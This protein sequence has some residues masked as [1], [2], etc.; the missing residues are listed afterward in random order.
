M[1]SHEKKIE[2]MQRRAAQKIEANKSNLMNNILKWL[3]WIWAIVLILLFVKYKTVDTETLN[4]PTISDHEKW[5]TWDVV[6][7]EYS[8]FQC[9][10]CAQMHK[11]IDDS[12][13]FNEDK[14]K[15]V[16][17]H[18]PLEAHK[19]SMLA[20]QFAEAAW[21]QWKFW[22]MYDQLFTKQWE[23][24]NLDDA[25][26]T[27]IK[28]AT[29]LGLDVAK[30]EKDISSPEV[31]NK[32]L[33]D[34]KSWDLQHITSTPTLIINWQKVEKNPPHKYEFMNMVVREDKKLNPKKYEEKPANWSWEVPPALFWSGSVQTG[35]LPVIQTWATE[36]TTWTQST[37]W[38]WA[39]PE[40]ASW[41]KVDTAT[42]AQQNEP[43]KAET[44]AT[45]TWSKE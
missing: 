15:L 7:I 33:A 24:A 26:P 1:W 4:K 35:S 13:F 19:F 10:A 30:L 32:I 45:N 8:D 16:F 27:F 14:M 20:S 29:E 39:Q 44:Q 6:V 17:R 28:F 22:E 42:W 34:K 21:M 11:I 3:M 5:S 36:M 9:P 12:W 25:K 41:A 2:K 38:T 40:I 23:W 37:A 18:Y 43:A 31:I